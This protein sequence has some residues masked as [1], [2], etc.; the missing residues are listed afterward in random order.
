MLVNLNPAGVD[1]R[2]VNCNS[3]VSTFL[4]GGGLQIPLEHKQRTN[5]QDHLKMRI[6]NPKP[7]SS[8]L[9]V[10]WLSLLRGCRIRVFFPRYWPNLEA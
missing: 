3:P 4:I 5:A 7:H 8:A 10:M 9:E 2:L 6:L 1:V